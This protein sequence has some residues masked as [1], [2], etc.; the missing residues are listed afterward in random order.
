MQHSEQT[1]SS[2]NL[3]SI[4]PRRKHTPGTIGQSSIMHPAQLSFLRKPIINL[5]HIPTVWKGTKKMLMLQAGLGFLVN[6]IFAV[7][8]FALVGL[9]VFVRF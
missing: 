1:P 9:F 7:F 5:H 3:G 8:V 2:S 6:L 4:S